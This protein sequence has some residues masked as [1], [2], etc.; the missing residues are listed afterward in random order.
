MTSKTPTVQRPK[1]RGRLSKNFVSNNIRHTFNNYLLH[2][3][4]PD[5]ESKLESEIKSDCTVIACRF[6]FPNWKEMATLGEGI[7]SVWIYKPQ[8]QGKKMMIDDLSVS[9]QLCSS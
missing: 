7:D 1:S 3:Q 6:P 9:T 8:Q 2:F 5:L 4:M